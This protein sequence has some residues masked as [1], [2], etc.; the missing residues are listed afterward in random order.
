[1]PDL[2]KISDAEWEVMNVVWDRTNPAAQDVVDARQLMYSVREE[3][4]YQ[5]EG[6][7]LAWKLGG[8]AAMPA[9]KPRPPQP[10][11]ARRIGR[12]REDAGPGK[13]AQLGHAL[14]ASGHQR[15][16]GQRR[17]QGA[18]AERGPGGPERPDDR[19]DPG[20]AEVV[21]RIIDGHAEE[22][23]AEGP[24]DAGAYHAHAPQQQRNGTKKL[25][26]YVVRR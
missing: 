22:G 16:V 17:A 19:I 7:L 13:E 21:Q 15:Q 3:L 4:D 5:N 1:M 9:V 8:K 20:P 10:V 11:P 6:R 24:G 14:G 12:G 26:Q 2:P 25:D 18:Q 23:E